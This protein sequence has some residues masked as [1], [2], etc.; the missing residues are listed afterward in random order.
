[1]HVVLLS[2]IVLNVIRL[3]VILMHV[4]LMATILLSGVLPSVTL[5]VVILLTVILLR[6]IQVS[7]ILL[8][9]ILP[10]VVAPPQPNCKMPV[11]KLS[12]HISPKQAQKCT[13]HNW[14]ACILRY[15]IK[16]NDAPPVLLFLFLM[17]LAAAKIG[18]LKFANLFKFSGLPSR[19]ALSAFQPC[20]YPLLPLLI[21]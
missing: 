8:N 21:C 4:I 10:N 5:F 13:E 1:M 15:L 11:L 16:Q 6:I 9:I 14:L 20:L 3:K 19:P 7:I 18:Q 12:Y 17:L 2:V